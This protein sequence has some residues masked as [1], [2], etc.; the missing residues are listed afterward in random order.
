[1]HIRSKFD[2][3]K[4]INISQRGSWEGRCAGAGLR[5][6]EGPGWEPACWAK[7]TGSEANKCF[8]SVS[9]A[10]SKKVSANYKRKAKDDVKLQ[11][12]RRKRSDNSLQSHLN[13]SRHDNRGPNTTEVPTDICIIKL[14]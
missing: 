8:K 3:G 12:K 9:A 11:R 1:M 6:N 7:V 2:G 10:K 13:Y 5:V 14:T 4:Q